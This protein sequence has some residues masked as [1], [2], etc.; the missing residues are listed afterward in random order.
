MSENDGGQ[1][2]S[3]D[4]EDV[5]GCREVGSRRGDNEVCFQQSAHHDPLSNQLP[6]TLTSRNDTPQHQSSNHTKQALARPTTTP[7]ISPSTPSIP[8]PL[9]RPPLPLLRLLLRQHGQARITHVRMVERGDG[10]MREESGHPSQRSQVARRREE[11][12][13]S[14]A[15]LVMKGWIGGRRSE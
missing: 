10:A 4:E 5:E 15:S 9:P 11:A 13:C 12:A 7:P 1:D 14:R 2:N 6:K 3:K 8:L